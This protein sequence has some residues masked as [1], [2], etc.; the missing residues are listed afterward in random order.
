MDNNLLRS[1]TG[2]YIGCMV[3]TVLTNL[4]LGHAFSITLAQILVHTLW[5]GWVYF[6]DYTS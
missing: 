2:F 1:A 3:G 5:L 4:F 6:Y